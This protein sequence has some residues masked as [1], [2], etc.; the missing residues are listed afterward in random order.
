MSFDK[1][2]EELY[3]QICDTLPASLVCGL[4]RVSRSLHAPA[5]MVLYRN[6]RLTELRS[7]IKVSR[8]LTKLNRST[9]KS[10][11]DAVRRLCVHFPR[12]STK[13]LDIFPRHLSRT[14]NTILIHVPNIMDLDF[15]LDS[16][17]GA[18]PEQFLRPDLPIN[19]HTFRTNIAFDASLE[20][21][22]GSPVCAN[23]RTLQVIPSHTRGAPRLPLTLLP[24]L[25]HLAAPDYIVA[26]LCCARPIRTLRIGP[27][28]IYDGML[29]ALVLGAAL[30]RDAAENLVGL[31]VEIVP[32]ARNVSTI[33]G[34]LPAVQKFVIRL[35]S[36][37]SR[38]ERQ[39]ERD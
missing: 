7:L 39:R 5:T 30:A 36:L 20:S 16:H 3:V 37:V 23:L 10:N 18:D 35:P 22:L 25:T 34:A 28:R 31:D 4:T 15:I 21:F 13:P 38:P 1:L 2:P 33:S 11:G 32:N 6:I 12:N 29:R 27:G 26:L 17:Q 19:L 14:I 8:A 9:G 24:H